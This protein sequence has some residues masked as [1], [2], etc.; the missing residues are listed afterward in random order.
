MYLVIIYYGDMSQ[1][2]WTA[3]HHTLA[4][5]LGV[6]VL[7]GEVRCD[8]EEGV[9]GDLCNRSVWSVKLINSLGAG[10]SNRY[11]PSPPALSGRTS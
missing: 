11:H 4:P 3:N 7:T 6:K 10:G 5:T 9:G 1:T 2:Q 8:A